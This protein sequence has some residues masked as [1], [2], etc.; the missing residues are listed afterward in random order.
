MKMKIKNTEVLQEDKHLRK[1]NTVFIV[2]K[3]PS[4]LHC[5]TGQITSCDHVS[6]I[7]S[8]PRNKVSLVHGFQK[9]YG[10]PGGILSL[11][12]KHFETSE[13]SEKVSDSSSYKAKFEVL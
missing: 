11:G 3:R 2:P 10:Y 4:L 8:N 9:T 1:N 7:K 6:F 12:I 13:E 5:N